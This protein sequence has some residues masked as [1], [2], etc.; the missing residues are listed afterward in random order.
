MASGNTQTNGVVRVVLRRNQINSWFVSP[1]HGSQS[2]I[3]E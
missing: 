3:R 2:G 1:E